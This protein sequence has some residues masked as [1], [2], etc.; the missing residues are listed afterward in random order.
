M[1]DGKDVP[2]L[3]GPG[4]GRLWDG[5]SK[6]LTTQLESVSLAS[7]YSS[8]L[9]HGRHADAYGGGGCPL[10]EQ[11]RRESQTQALKGALCPRKKASI[12]IFAVIQQHQWEACKQE[13]LLFL[14]HPPPITPSCHFAIKHLGNTPDE[15]WE[16]AFPGLALCTMAPDYSSCLGILE[17]TRS[18]VLIRDLGDVY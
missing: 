13:A 10:K 3:G 4:K 5:K 9:S 17:L 12:G 14:G 8:L 6:A 15:L 7:L 11:G 2:F 1:Q 18:G 16:A